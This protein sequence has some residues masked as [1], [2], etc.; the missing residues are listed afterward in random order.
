MVLTAV[1]VSAQA[2]P[3][4]RI[5][6]VFG[7]SDFLD[8]QAIAA[9][10]AH[11]AWLL[12]LVPDPEPTF[13]TQRWNGS[14]WVP[15]AL[16]ARL[17]NVIGPWALFSG[18]YTTSSS[19]TWFFPVLPDRMTPVQYALRWNGSV[20]RLSVVAASPD[21]VLDAAVF[22]AS[23]VWAFG[24]AGASFSRYGPA[25]VRHWNGTAWRTVSVPGGTPV[26]VDA[27]AP[28]DIWALGVSQ[29]TV[30]QVHQAIVAMHWNGTAWSA[31][32]LPAMPPVRPGYPWV[33]TA[34]SATGPRDAWVAETP[35]VNQQT[36]FSPPGLLL[37]HWNGSTWRT[38]AKNRTLHGAT[39][40]TPDGHGGFWLTATAPANPAAG[41][42][43]DYR[44]GTFTSQPAPAPH[45]YTG[46]ASGI[47]AVPGTGSFWATGTLTAVKGGTDE[48]DILRY[49]P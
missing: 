11:N 23:D 20:W 17:R 3:G 14:R 39:G 41:D 30:H 25:V 46:T 5:E 4:W 6:K 18:I 37:F 7:R 28:G 40:L 19:D 48:T 31:S 49:S 10:G 16:P 33:A 29:A 1:P 24:E 15:I 38:V 8:V 21:T 32:R 12:G 42:I 44:H 47:V 2:A 9:S 36:G 45:G 13:V 26:T 35:A 43:I 34:I 27:V 22:S